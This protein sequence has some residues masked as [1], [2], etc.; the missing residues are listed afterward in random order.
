MYFSIAASGR[1]N[2][3]IEIA[4]PAGTRLFGYKL[5]LLEGI[6]GTVYEEKSVRTNIQ[7][8]SSNVTVTGNYL[9]I[10]SLQDRHRL[11]NF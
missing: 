4:G 3:F 10:L 6:F 2:D 8:M 5:L 1:R 9:K 11:T 7:S